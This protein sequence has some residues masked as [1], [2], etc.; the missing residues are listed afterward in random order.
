MYFTPGAVFYGPINPD[1]LCEKWFLIAPQ[2]ELDYMRH[3]FQTT[4]PLLMYVDVTRL[5]FGRHIQAPFCGK[6]ARFTIILLIS[7]RKPNGV[8]TRAVAQP[9]PGK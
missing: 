6:W 1:L 3:Q 2:Q 4:P 5:W 9:T 7:T 8:A